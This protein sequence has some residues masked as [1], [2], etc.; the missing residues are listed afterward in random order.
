MADA[1]Y[2]QDVCGG[3]RAWEVDALLDPP[4]PRS[5]LSDSEH[6]AFMDLSRRARAKGEARAAYAYAEHAYA[7]QRRT[8]VLQVLERRPRR[9]AVASRA[10]DH[11]FGCCVC[12]VCCALCG[13]ALSRACG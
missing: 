7:G 11:P 9:S 8:E 2:L 12:F 5:P 6:D 4:A 1:R 10:D 3:V 13:C